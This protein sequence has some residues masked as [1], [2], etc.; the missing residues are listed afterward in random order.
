MFNVHVD[1]I[2]FKSSFSPLLCSFFPLFSPFLT[3]FVRIVLMEYFLVFYFI[4][5]YCWIWI[6]RFTCVCL[7]FPVVALGFIKYIFFFFFFVLFFSFAEQ[8]VDV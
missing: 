2:G 1:M 8:F 7:F 6:T 3:S 4:L 5:D